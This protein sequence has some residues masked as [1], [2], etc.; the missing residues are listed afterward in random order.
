MPKYKE[1]TSPE[2]SAIGIKAFEGKLISQHVFI[3]KV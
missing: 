3:D 1:W 2:Q